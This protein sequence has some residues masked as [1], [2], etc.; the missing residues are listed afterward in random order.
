MDRLLV[1]ACLLGVNCKY[2]G[3]NNVLP[4][5]TLE[6][7]RNKYILIPVCPETAG[8]LPVP[9]RP[10]ERRHDI[11]VDD[12]GND[13]TKQFTKGAE[14]AQVLAQRYAIF[15]ALLK[16][17]SPSCGC[18]LIYDGSFSGALIPGDGVAAEALKALGLKVYGES[19]VEELL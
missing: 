10:S 17:N 12:L 1:S 3:G 16:E 6:K 19:R 18:G 7:L 2:S 13:V 5:E 9:R 14:T 8:G 11:V 15:S 4:R